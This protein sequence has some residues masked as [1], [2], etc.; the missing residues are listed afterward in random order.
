MNTQNPTR[1]LRRRLG[2][3]L[4]AAFLLIGAAAC[5]SEG[6]TG[7]AAPLVKPIKLAE[8]HDQFAAGKPLSAAQC[9]ILAPDMGALIFQ[10]ASNFVEAASASYS[11]HED[12]CQIGQINSSENVDLHIELAP[13]SAI[14][15]SPATK[16]GPTTIQSRLRVGDQFMLTVVVETKDTRLDTEVPTLDAWLQKVAD[17]IDTSGMAG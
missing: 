17:R 9:K 2:I 16:V 8:L 11:D 14:M 7:V 13:P 15:S 3:V 4:G 1:S 10:P 6:G 12:V 5:S